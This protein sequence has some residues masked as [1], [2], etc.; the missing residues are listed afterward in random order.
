MHLHEGTQIRLP[1]LALKPSG[2]VT[3]PPKQEYYWPD[4]KE[5]CPPNKF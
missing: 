4:K 5:L 1:T 3:R 2:D